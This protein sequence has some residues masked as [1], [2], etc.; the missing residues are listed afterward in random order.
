MSRASRLSATLLR[1]L[2][3][4][5]VIAAPEEY[6]ALAMPLDRGLNVLVER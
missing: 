2:V 1:L 4:R 6:P 3:D 5:T